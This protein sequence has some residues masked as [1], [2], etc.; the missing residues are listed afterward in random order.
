MNDFDPKRLRAAFARYMTGVTV[1]TTRDARGEPVGF[2]A[3]S[4]TSVSLD[5]PLLLVCPGRHLSSFAVFQSTA[6]FRHQHSGGGSGRG[7]EPL[8]WPRGRPVC[9]LR[10]GRGVR[11]AFR[12]SRAGRRGFPVRHMTG[13]RQGDHLVLI[14]RIEAFDHSDA[15]GL[16]YG[17][18]GYF[19]L[20]K[21]REAMSATATRTRTSVLLD[22][23]RCVYLT[24]GGDLPTVEASADHNPLAALRGYL[25]A[26]GIAADPGVVYS[27]YDEGN[28]TRRL[29]FRAR[30]AAPAPALVAKPIHGL[31]AAPV[32]DPAVHAMLSRFETEFQNQSFGLYV[33]DDRQGDI[34]P[35]SDPGLG[36]APD[37]D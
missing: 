3:N 15:N 18:S 11:S 28:A 31:S 10:L 21:E 34:L 19:S 14:G 1:V 12:S 27:I 36:V 16:G 25:A 24:E 13:S 6:V 8:C 26:K 20:G 9:A 7:L 17:P 32:P 29:V 35:G 5:P 37:G 33:G 22:D 4:F 30:L 2:T 23:G